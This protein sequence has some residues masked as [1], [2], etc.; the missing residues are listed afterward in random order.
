MSIKRMN[1]VDLT[2]F[3]NY[4]F[5][6]F[7]NKRRKIKEMNFVRVSGK[8]GLINLWIS[9]SSY[10]LSFIL[11]LISFCLPDWILY[12]SIPVKIGLWRLCD[13]QVKILLF[14]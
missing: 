9:I 6:Q 11:Y 1:D 4:S 5:E 8:I 14:F 10:F 3:V 7:L 12:T 2:L 13:I